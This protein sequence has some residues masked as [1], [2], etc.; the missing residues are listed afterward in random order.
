MQVYRGLDIGTAKPSAEEQAHV[1]HHLIDVAEPHETFDASRFLNL[2][3]AAEADI[4]RRGRVPI[5]CGGTGLYFKALLEGLEPGVGADPV[6]RE[7]LEAL[8]NHQLSARLRE[9]DPVAYE[10]ID[11][12]NRRRLVRALEVIHLT[13]RPFS[14]QRRDWSAEPEEQPLA[15]NPSHVGLDRERDDLY[16]RINERVDA[17]FARGLVEETQLLMGRGL[18]QNATAMQAIGYRQVVEHLE[19]KRSLHETVEAVKTAT[20]RFA[21]RQ[22][23]WFRNQMNLRWF[24]LTD[25]TTGREERES[26]PAR[27]SKVSLQQLVNELTAD[28]SPFLPEQKR[29]HGN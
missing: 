9:L 14:E 26:R 22:L 8:D 2:A 16:T 19:G 29:N 10:R 23:T 28:W 13:G 18:S 11:R 5:F 15:L 27:P 7:S 25:A 1:P 12:S 6:F 17:M 21:K 4:L 24:Q 3:L 20:R